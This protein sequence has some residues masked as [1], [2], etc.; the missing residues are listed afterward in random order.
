MQLACLQ[1]GLTFCPYDPKDLTNEGISQRVQKL[2]I[3]CVITNVENIEIARRYTNNPIRPLKKGLIT[4]CSTSEPLPVGWIHLMRSAHDAE[5]EFTPKIVAQP[6]T[7]VLRFLSNENQVIQYSQK[8]F[9]LQLIL[10]A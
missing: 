6:E 5:T 9:N 10:S 1:S 2:A 3:D 4:N 8:D 7:P